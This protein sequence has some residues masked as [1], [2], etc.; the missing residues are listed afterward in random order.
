MWIKKIIPIIENYYFKTKDILNRST[1]PIRFSSPSSFFLT[2]KCA[3]RNAPKY[4]GFR[5]YNF[6]S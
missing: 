4:M 5:F 2:Q 1:T 6:I 3:H